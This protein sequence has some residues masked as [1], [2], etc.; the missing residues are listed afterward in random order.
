[1]LRSL[2]LILTCAVSP[3]AALSVPARPAQP[4]GGV[5]IQEIP[6]GIRLPARLHR[7]A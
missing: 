2:C 1:M 5:Y 4:N 3:V 7:P 6:S